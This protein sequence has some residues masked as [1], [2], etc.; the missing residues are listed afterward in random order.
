MIKSILSTKIIK[1]ADSPIMTVAIG[2]KIFE[3]IN[4]RNPRDRIR[5][6]T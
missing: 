3:I 2:L 5:G 1:F 6:L 4:N